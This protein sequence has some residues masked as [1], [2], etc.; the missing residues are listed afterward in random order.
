MKK[1]KKK[2]IV[3]VEFHQ[4]QDQFGNIFGKAHP[5]GVWHDNPKTQ[6]FHD[7]TEESKTQ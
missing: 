4:H 6:K 5:V 2:K 7:I 1:A 3:P